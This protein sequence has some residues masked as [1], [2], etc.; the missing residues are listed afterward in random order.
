MLNSNE[1]LSPDKFSNSI[2]QKPE[3]SLESLEKETAWQEYPIEGGLVAVKGDTSIIFYPHYSDMVH[4]NVAPSD[5]VGKVIK[6]TTLTPQYFETHTQVADFQELL[7]NF[8][9]QTLAL[10]DIIDY[11]KSL[12]DNLRKIEQLVDRQ[13]K[14]ELIQKEIFQLAQQLV[15][16][17]K[18]KNLY[19]STVESCTGGGLANAIT[20]ISGASEIMKESFITYSNEAKIKLGVPKEIID[21]Y[22][23]YS[24]ETARAMAVAGLRASIKADIGVGVT[25]S[26]SR[27]D[28]ANPNSKPGEVYLGVVY[29]DKIESKKFVFADEGERYEV[30]DRAILEALKMVNDIIEEPKG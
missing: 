11:D 4:P 24:E 17:L 25:G 15:T 9:W 21:K 22:T 5:Y 27:V 29:Q 19:V 28:P 12:E 3:E 14:Q 1:K 7:I 23:V 13:K 10:N 16:K 26:I 8:P 6:G 30:K 2:N 18:E 20:N